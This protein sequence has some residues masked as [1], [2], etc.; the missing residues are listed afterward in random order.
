[1][2]SIAQVSSGDADGGEAALGRLVRSTPSTRPVMTVTSLGQVPSGL[3]G[4]TLDKRTASATWRPMRPVPVASL[5]VAPRSRAP[6]VVG[7]RYVAA[8]IRA[9]LLRESTW[10]RRL[11][12]AAGLTAATMVALL[13][14]V[15]I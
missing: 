11:A 14:L 7:A 10:P 8:E 12:I 15:K 5:G 2:A 9:A 4:L 1:M 3:V 13:E 6:L